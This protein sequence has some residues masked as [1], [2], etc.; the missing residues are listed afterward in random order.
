TAGNSL[1]VFAVSR[2]AFSN[3]VAN[4]AAGAW[5]LPVKTGGVADGDLVPAGDSKSAVFTGHLIGTATVRATSGGLTPTEA[6][7]L[8][9]VA[10]VAARLAI[11]TAPQTLTAGVS[12][13]AIR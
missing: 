3:F 6:G 10:G 11:T 4:V 13:G 9:V 7:T 12:S 5:S 2:D 1:T 8:T